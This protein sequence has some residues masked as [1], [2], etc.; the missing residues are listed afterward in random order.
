MRQ[1]ERVIGRGEQ[2]ASKRGGRELVMSAYDSAVR[3]I[4]ASTARRIRLRVRLFRRDRFPFPRRGR[5]G[6]RPHEILA[7][8]PGRARPGKQA[9]P[10]HWRPVVSRSPQ[11]SASKAR[12]AG[13]TAIRP[14]WIGVGLRLEMSNGSNRITTSVVQSVTIDPPR[15]SK[16]ADERRFRFDVA[17]I[18]AH[19]LTCFATACLLGR[20]YR[21]SFQ[22]LRASASLRSRSQSNGQLE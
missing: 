2:F 7:L 6:Q 13:G 17:S 11:R 15:G 10:R 1:H 3:R 4:S 18:S 9:R 5:S 22:R 20:M 16:S 19:V 8:P 21:R 12:P 14:G